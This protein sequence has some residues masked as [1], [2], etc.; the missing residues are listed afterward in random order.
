MNRYESDIY[1]ARYLGTRARQE[2]Y[3]AGGSLPGG[4]FLILA[5]GM[6]GHADGNVAS[7]TAVHA[8]AAELG[9]SGDPRTAA[10]AA[11]Q[12]LAEYKSAGKM[13]RSAGCT[14]I[15]ATVIDGLCRWASIGD[16]YLLCQKAGQ[17]VERINPLHTYGARLDAMVERGEMSAEAAQSDPKRA[18]LTSAVMGDEIEEC[19]EGELTL[20]CGDRLILASDGY[21][22]MGQ[23]QLEAFL[24]Q[25]PATGRGDAEMI[26]TTI[27]QTVKQAGRPKQDN[28]SVLVY[29]LA[30]VQRK[31]L[32]LPWNSHSVAYGLV[33]SMC[34]GLLLLVGFVS[35]LMMT[36]KDNAVA[37]ATSQ[38]AP[39]P[40]PPVAAAPAEQH[41]QPASQQQEI[42]K[43]EDSE[44]V[45]NK[46]PEPVQMTVQKQMN[47]VIADKDSTLW[48]AYHKN[49]E[50]N[51]ENRDI[52]P[53]TKI[54][55]LLSA[56]V[57]HDEWWK[58]VISALKP[59]GEGVNL[60]NLLKK[61]TDIKTA[62]AISV[63]W[64]KK[65]DA[66]P[67]DE[68]RRND[69]LNVIPSDRLDS[70]LSALWGTSFRRDLL[71][72][73]MSEMAKAEDDKKRKEEIVKTL[74]EGQTDDAAK[75]GL[76]DDWKNEEALLVLLWNTQEDSREVMLSLAIQMEENEGQ[77]IIASINEEWLKRLKTIADSQ[78]ANNRSLK[79]S[80]KESA[81]K[82]LGLENVGSYIEFQKDN[83]KC[84]R[85]NVGE[86]KN[87][88]KD[89]KIIHFNYLQQPNGIAIQ[90]QPQQWKSF[91][92]QYGDLVYLLDIK[93][94]TTPQNA[95]KKQ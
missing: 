1:A 33:G 74:W 28:T 82:Y 43:N 80:V 5:D 9:R 11:N 55:Y 17:G 76:L 94:P 90:E 61:C 50:E 44:R 30:P 59:E 72:P 19:S 42:V 25:H 48:A 81:V 68:T 73:R 49:I 86:D 91:K 2:D 62:I 95:E 22:T 71:L 35:A 37:V 89:I 18:A 54:D 31:R 63:E 75:K 78:D 67:E 46:K 79:D 34:A 27:L 10:M 29:E 3:V 14:L 13:D 15:I 39:N 92:Q 69:F 83:N 52:L 51:W 12:A 36:D 53:D 47:A 20:A 57:P 45:D 6:G 60:E 26:A 70:I 16:S 21:L 23:K 58:G 77:K 7:E 64:W 93:G 84:V 88:G 85:L 65:E 66:A 24:L 40:P 8:A 4:V 38:A 32:S 41:P 87:V 56:N